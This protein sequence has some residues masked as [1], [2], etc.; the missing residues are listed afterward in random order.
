M[1]QRMILA[2]TGLGALCMAACGGGTSSST[3]GAFRIVEA[4]NGFGKLLP[5]RIE[6]LDP[7]TGFGSGTTI[8]INSF[9]D[10]TSN[11]TPL[12]TIESPIKWQTGAVLPNNAAGNHF[13]YVRF[14]QPI[15]IDSVLTSAATSGVDNN[16]VGNIQVVQVIVDENGTTVEPLPGR[17]FVGGRTYAGTPDINGQLPLQT[18]VGLSD[19][20][21][22]ALTVEGGTPGL[23]FPGTQADYNGANQLVSPNVFLF[24]ADT[25]GN[26]A[27]HETF[28][29]GVQIQMKITKGTLNS[30]GRALEEQGVASSTVG[31][32]LLGPEVL[33]AGAAQTPVI[34]PSDLEQNVDPETNIELFFTEPIQF[35]TV[36]DLDDGT[37]PSESFAV[38][39]QFGSSTMKVTVPFSVMPA[40]IYDLTHLILQPLYN[41]PGSSPTSS[42]V[43]CGDFS[44]IDVTINAGTFSDLTG[45]FNSKPQSSMFTTA[46]GPGLVNAPVLPDALYVGRGGSSGGISVIDLNGFGQGPGNHEYDPAE[47]IKFGNTN[48]MNDPNYALQGAALIP[49]LSQGTCSVN[50]GSAGV[51]TLAVDSSLSDLLVTAP[52][53]E[54][55]GDMA[56]GHALDNSFNNAAPFGCQAGGGNICATSGFK[57]ITIATGGSA[58]LVPGTTNATVF[59]IK[60][61]FGT[62]N[63]V[64]FSPHPNPPPLVFPPLCLSPLIGAQEPTSVANSIFVGGVVVTQATNLL[65]PAANALGNA[66]IG[67]PPQGIIS[68][69]QNAFFQGPSPPQS[70]V[71]ACSPYMIR[72]QIGNFLYVVDRARGE[73]VVLNSNRMTVLDRIALPDPTSLAMSPNLDFIA[74]TNERANQVTFINTNPAS[75]QFHQIAGTTVVG[76][77]PSGI[78]WTPDN[79]DILVVNS[80]DNT[81]SILSAF[82]FQTRKVVRNQLRG[83]REVIITPRQNGFGLQRAV[84]FA[85]ILNSDGSVAIFE[86]GPDGINGW[87]FD[88]VIGIVPF[89]F[90]NA[91]T[92][93]VDPV[94]LDSRFF[95]AHENR[96]SLITGENDGD[97]GGALSSCGMSSGNLGR[98]PLEAGSFSNPRLRDIQFKIFSSVGSDQLT[99]VPVDIAFDNLKNRTALTNISNPYTVSLPLSINGKSVIKTG[100]ATCNSPQF[101]F[102][103][104]P[105]SSEGS[106]VVDVLSI[107]SGLIREDTNPFIR[108][109]QSIPVPNVTVIVDYL[110]Q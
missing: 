104:V 40:S 96:K 88:D 4:S 13:I 70:S 42:A 52:L 69:E 32:D 33:V 99:G 9:S 67:L 46:V 100:S 65:V 98:V 56:I 31:D 20:K 35:L 47:P 84:Y 49:P 87:G 8:E 85:Y 34:I 102:L 48:M 108:G 24:V 5:Y 27:T 60:T 73:V 59:P 89:T 86:S 55:V 39:L 38:Q 1:N 28:P 12:N 110:R 36:G 106:G 74:V 105:A 2:L 10:L 26:L 41:F 93:V 79:E 72:Q 64:S 109:T 94:R 75:S 81:M 18:W 78:A 57:V 95:I 51:F 62:E 44:N 17:G 14:N 83:P 91:K 68:T 15:D 80:G 22:T 66:E 103:A 37:P 82:N 25:D 50:G 53:I 58:T 45:N 11:L 90:D 19:S 107:D 71:G 101:V 16:L 43:S 77:G 61:E 23:G 92:L 6:K 7:N 29:E 63:L 97:T 21:P 30:K 3:S 76:K 54:T